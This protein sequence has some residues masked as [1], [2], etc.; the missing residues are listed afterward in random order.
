[1]QGFRHGAKFLVGLDEATIDDKG[2]ILIGKKQRERLGEPFALCL[3]PTGCLAAYPQAI[4]E[5]QVI[6]VL[7]HSSINQGREQ[8]SRLLMGSAADE[9]KFDAQGRVVIPQKLREMAQLK[10]RVLLVGC[11]DRIEIWAHQEWDKY[12]A[13]PDA[14]GQTRREAMARAEQKMR[15][16]R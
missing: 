6:E 10:D 1:V 7:S 11:G 14:Y 16:G 4:W 3:T 13:D 9:L 5:E 8:Y 12:E 15:E 2:R